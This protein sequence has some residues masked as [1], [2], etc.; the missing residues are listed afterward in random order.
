MSPNHVVILKF[1]V[2]LCNKDAII[3]FLKQAVRNKSIYRQ[4]YI[5]SLN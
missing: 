5:V 2:F 4:E 1:Q 3:S